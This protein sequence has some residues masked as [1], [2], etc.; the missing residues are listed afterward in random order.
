CVSR[1]WQCG[2]RRRSTSR[3]ARLTGPTPSL[4]SCLT[5]SGISLSSLWQQPFSPPPSRSAPPAHSASC[6]P[7]TC[8]SVSF[9]FSAS[10]SSTG[11]VAARVGLECSRMMREMGIS[12]SGSTGSVE[13]I[14]LRGQVDC[15][16]I[17]KHLE[18]G[19]TMFSFIWWIIG[20]YWVSAGGQALSQDAPQLYWLSIVFLAFD[21]FFVVFCVGLACLIGIVVC[22]FLPCIIAILYAVTDQV[23]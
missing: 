18:S 3:S 5:C 21:V 16:P 14:D 12:S 23:C 11:A 9:T 7:V 17:V 1:R 22:C 20:F 2:R 15:A 10:S 13:R 8:C 4:S 6:L 19:N